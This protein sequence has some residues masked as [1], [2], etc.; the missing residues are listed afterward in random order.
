MWVYAGVVTQGVPYAYFY[1]VAVE[2]LS[3]WMPSYPLLA[4]TIVSASYCVSQVIVSLVLY[5]LIAMLGVVNA[6]TVTSAALFV[7]C[8]IC[9][10][11]LRFPTEKDKRALS[12]V[13]TECTTCLLSPRCAS[14]QHATTAGE[15]EE[16]EET[17]VQAWHELLKQG[18]FYRYIAVVFLGRTCVGVYNY[19][20]KLGYV[21]NLATPRVIS[22]FQLLALCTL[23]WTLLA[24]STMEYIQFRTGKHATVTRVVLVV[25]Y[26]TQAL[27][28]LW[29][30]GLSTGW[31]NNNDDGSKEEGGM[32]AMI[33]ISVVVG[34]FESQT[35]YVVAL[36]RTLFGERNGTTAFGMSVGLAMSPG[37]AMFTTLVALIETRQSVN[38]AAITPG[39]FCAFYVIG[40]GCLLLGGVLV[41]L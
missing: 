11:M 40:S 41:A 5:T 33:M 10:L 6:L 39:T 3:C 36:A 21:Y 38:G 7:S 27:L 13:T 24:N 8:S 23:S 35:A 34:L 31:D 12:P 28:L 4:M 14:P 1:L 2:A 26:I 18:T 19:Y 20:F 29:L 25:V 17:T 22:L 9:G 16:E 30:A 37:D 32:K 15:T